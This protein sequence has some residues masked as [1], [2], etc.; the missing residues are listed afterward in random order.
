VTEKLLVIKL[1]IE[2]KSNDYLENFK[3]I[4]RKI[5]QLRYLEKCYELSFMLVNSIVNPDLAIA[6]KRLYQDYIQ[7][8]KILLTEK[9]DL[10]KRLSMNLIQK[11]QAWFPNKINTRKIGINQLYIKCFQENILDENI[12]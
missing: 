10:A 3:D 9:P 8:C 6:K 11:E 5:I 7:E 2:N 12:Y 4:F 1:K